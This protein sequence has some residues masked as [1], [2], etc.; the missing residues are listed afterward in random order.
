[1]QWETFQLTHINALVGNTKL[2]YTHA[3]GNEKEECHHINHIVECV[4]GKEENNI[5]WKL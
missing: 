4:I 1:M 5:P 3:V 2:K